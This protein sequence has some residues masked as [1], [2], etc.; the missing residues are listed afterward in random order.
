MTLY[1]TCFLYAPMPS[2]RDKLKSVLNK[3]KD[4]VTISMFSGNRG[5]DGVSVVE[6]Q[7]SKVGSQR[8]STLLLWSGG[9]G[10]QFWPCFPCW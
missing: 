6:R 3:K 8:T 2:R 5:G 7:C 10:H 1:M 9:G 4:I